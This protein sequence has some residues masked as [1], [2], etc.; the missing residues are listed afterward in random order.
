MNESDPV[1]NWTGEAGAEFRRS[2]QRG[3]GETMSD[4][5]AVSHLKLQRCEVA[6]Q[7]GVQ[8]VTNHTVGFVPPGKGEATE[9]QN[10]KGTQ[11]GP[12]A[13]RRHKKKRTANEKGKTSKKIKHRTQT[14]NHMT[15]L[16]NGKHVVIVK[17]LLTLIITTTIY[18]FL[19]DFD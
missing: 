6:P 5:A 12:K 14:L 7:T 10:K 17:I 8:L 11:T 15:L 4:G 1:G 3:M 19:T 18:A 13:N 2:G 9:R 16:F